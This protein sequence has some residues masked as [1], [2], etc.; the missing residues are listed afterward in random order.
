MNDDNNDFGITFQT[1]DVND[2]TKKSWSNESF[3][4]IT[5]EKD[6]D[7]KRENITSQLSMNFYGRKKDQKL[8][9]Q[10]EIPSDFQSDKIFYSTNM[11]NKTENRNIDKLFR[12]DKVNSHQVEDG[13]TIQNN[14]DSL[15]QIEKN[16]NALQQSKI[17]ITAYKSKFLNNISPNNLVAKTFTPLASNSK[18]VEK[19]F[20]ESNPQIVN[21]KNDIPDNFV[22]NLT[23]INPDTL[24][25]NSI[26]Q[27]NTCERR[28]SIKKNPKKKKEESPKNNQKV[29]TVNNTTP[30][31]TD[32]VELKNRI[33]SS[34]LI[35]KNFSSKICEILVE[36]N[37]TPKPSNPS[38]TKMTQKLRS[39]SNKTDNQKKITTIASNS[40]NNNS[41]IKIIRNYVTPKVEKSKEKITHRKKVVSKKDDSKNYSTSSRENTIERKTMNNF[42]KTKSKNDTSYANQYRNRSKSRPNNIYPNSKDHTDSKFTKS[43]FNN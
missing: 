4:S 38:V 3:V 10:V 18:N 16:L 25:N 28:A 36:R 13:K 30:K 1:K 41:F 33:A 26:L 37:L 8:H 21:K 9:S 42:F 39:G 23:D 5:L 24:E 11:V 43:M 35:K 2:T 27:Q 34:N 20:N 7:T 32:L 14:D 6:C 29:I 40:P 19:F 17:L 22:V 15:S 12:I 31:K